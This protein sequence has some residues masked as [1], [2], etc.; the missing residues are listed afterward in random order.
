MHV[1]KRV[2][3]QG[4]PHFS[5]PIRENLRL[6]LSGARAVASQL[7]K[8]V[9]SFSS[10]DSSCVLF[11]VSLTHT[12]EYTYLSTRCGEGPTTTL[13]GLHK[14]AKSPNFDVMAFMNGIGSR[15]PQLLRPLID[16]Y[17]TSV[18]FANSSCSFVFV[19]FWGLHDH[20]CSRTAAVREQFVRVRS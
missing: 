1:A 12:H 15:F 2:T 7:Q 9:R 11:G 6:C 4:H 13:A 17:K 10:L 14:D 16:R 20:T 8:T 3:G 19:L 5:T 18:V